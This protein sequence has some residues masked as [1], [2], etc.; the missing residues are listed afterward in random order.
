MV[1]AGNERPEMKLNEGQTFGA[2][3]SSAQMCENS[4]I[5]WR[6]LKTCRYRKLLKVW[7][8]LP[9]AGILE[10]GHYGQLWAS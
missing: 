3:I 4:G 2:S 9:P 6:T 7:S 5:D 1:I 10:R 8:L